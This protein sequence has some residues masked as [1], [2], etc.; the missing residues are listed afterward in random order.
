MTFKIPFFV[1]ETIN[2]LQKNGYEA[3]MVGGC[4]RDILMGNTPHDYDVTTNALPNQVKELFDRTADTGIKHGTVTVIW[5]KNTVEVT[6]Y[7]T[8]SEYTD[9]R[10]PDCVTFVTN[11]KEDLTRRD[12]TVN[13]ICY[14]KK[15]GFTDLFGGISDINNKILK[16][17]GDANIRFTEDALRILRLFR[18]ACTLNFKIDKNTYEAALCCLPLIKNVSIERIADE[19]KK[20]CLGDNFKALEQFINSGGLE[21][22][23]ITSCEELD[24]ISD[25]S[26]NIDLRL[27]ALLS[28]CDCDVCDIAKKLKLS[29]LS[30]NTISSLKYLTTNPPPKSKSDI[31]RI[32]A[33]FDYNVFISYLEY[34]AVIK[35][36]PTEEVRL[37][38]EEILN[39]KEP[40]KISQL[41]IGGNEVTKLGF[42]ERKVGEALNFLLE[43]VIDNPNY[44]KKETLIEFLKN[45][46]N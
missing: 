42:T 30:K 32:L 28:L 33:R 34:L 37:I 26:K 9:N 46:R 17:V 14:N 11:L 23:D 35:N 36:I 44:N 29:N 2:T 19:L 3:Y 27:F 21:C 39:N 18:F 41:A 45:Y 15:S 25:L 13:A 22:L 16:A 31:K 4:V 24:K 6:T 5:D 38:T 1:T 7:R 12:F 10:H 20:A 40:Y 43:S 8:E